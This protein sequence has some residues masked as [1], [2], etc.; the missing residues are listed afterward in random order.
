MSTV[1]NKK[2]ISIRLDSNLY[3]HIKKIE[4]L[5]NE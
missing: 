1:T 4:D 3:A 5:E 2:A